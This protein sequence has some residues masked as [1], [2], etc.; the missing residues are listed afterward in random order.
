MLIIFLLF[1]KFLKSMDLQC[2]VRR[3][4]SF[5]VEL[6]NKEINFWVVKNYIRIKL[7]NFQMGTEFIYTLSSLHSVINCTVHKTEQLLN[8]VPFI[9]AL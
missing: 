9:S 4:S 7:I 5:R 8:L 6:L 1:L 3:F 2:Y